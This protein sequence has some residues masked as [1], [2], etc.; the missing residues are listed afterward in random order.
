MSAILII[1][2][3]LLLFLDA[4]ARGA[5][6]IL[7]RTEKAAELYYVTSQQEIYE[8]YKKANLWGARVVH[9]NRFMNLVDYRPPEYSR[10]RPFPLKVEDVRPLYE[11][12]LDSHNWLFIA[13]RTGK[14]RSVAVVLPELL[15]NA[16]KAELASHFE[17]RIS[18]DTI[19]GHS[20]DLPVMV[21]TL[22]SL[23]IIEEPVVVNIDAGYFSNVEDP[24]YVAGRLKEK[25]PDVRML[26]VSESRD[27]PEIPDGARLLLA[28]FR[29]RWTGR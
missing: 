25:C 21:S 13:S 24:A 2:A 26:V 9:L 28:D 27:E 17:Y 22:D 20:F 11:K 1:V 10:S 8:I 23:P 7:Q 14:V 16:K 12:G 3:S 15:F 6:H 4:K 19:K 18:G 5:R 29:K